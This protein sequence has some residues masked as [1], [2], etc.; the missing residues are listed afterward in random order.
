M[1]LPVFA[2]SAQK[3]ALKSA[4]WF[5]GQRVLFR[6]VLFYR[7]GS[8]GIRHKFVLFAFFRPAKSPV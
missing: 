5:N 8:I 2:F 4:R 1:E 7:A 3:T 6:A